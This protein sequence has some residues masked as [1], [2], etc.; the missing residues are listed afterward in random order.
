LVLPRPKPVFITSS[1]LQWVRLD[2]AYYEPVRLPDKEAHGLALRLQAGPR[3]E[4]F[5]VAT[6]THSATCARRY[7]THSLDRGL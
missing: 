3:V 6:P 7:G 4:L 2:G 1:Q 5:D